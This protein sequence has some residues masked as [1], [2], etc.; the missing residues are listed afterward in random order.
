MCTSVPQM[1]ARLTR[2]S[3]SLIPGCGASISSSHKPGAFLLLTRA[4]IRFIVVCMR[5]PI[6]A[7]TLLALAPL[8]AQHSPPAAATWAIEQPTHHQ[9]VPNITYGVQN[10][11]ETKLDVSKRPGIGTTPQPT[12]IFIH[13]GGW[14]GGSKDSSLFS[15]PPFLEMGWNVVN[16]EYRLGRISLRPAAVEDFR[17]PFRR[18]AQHPGEDH[19]ETTRYVVS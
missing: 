9:I 7:L 13:G 17:C 2:I 16:V 11:Y 12:L 4:F 1:P 8:Y 3:T 6:L 5:I 15:F 18:T 10:N 19:I 14:V